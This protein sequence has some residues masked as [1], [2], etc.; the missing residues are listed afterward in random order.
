MFCFTYTSSCRS[1]RHDF[2]TS[3]IDCDTSFS[4]MLRLA[5]QVSRLSSFAFR[6]C[7]PSHKCFPRFLSLHSLAVYTSHFLLLS[8]DQLLLCIIAFRKSLV[9]EDFFASSSRFREKGVCPGV[10]PVTNSRHIYNREIGNKGGNCNSFRTYRLHPSSLDTHTH[11]DPQH[12]I[13]HD[14]CLPPP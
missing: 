5:V 3:S 2:L 7:L 8:H 9:T 1:T 14:F 13:P 11:C 4:Q 12:T 6:C 10:N